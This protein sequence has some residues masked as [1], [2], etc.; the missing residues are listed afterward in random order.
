MANR[1]RRTPGLPHPTAD[2][3]A[4]L[5]ALNR[6]LFQELIEHAVRGNIGFPKDGT[7]PF[8][9]ALPLMIA[10]GAFP[11]EAESEGRLLYDEATGRVFWCDGVDWIP[12]GS[13][14]GGGGISDGDKGDISVSGAGS[15][16]TIDPITVT[17]AKIQN[18]A[19]D[20]LIGRDTAASGSVEE[21]SVGGGLEFT[22]AAAIRRS[23]LTGDVTAGVGS[24]STTIA[25]DAVTF[26]KMQDLTDARLVGRASGAPGDPEHISVAAPLTLAATVLGFDAAADLSNNARVAVRKNSAGS[27]FIR[28]RINLIE[29][30]NVTL[31]VA[32]DAGNEEVDVTVAASGGGG[33]SVNSGTTSVDF[34]AGASNANDTH[35]VVTV[36]GQAGIVAGSLV[37]AWVRGTTSADHNID[38]HMVDELKVEAGNIVAGT[39]FDIHV[40]CVRGKTYGVYNLNWMWV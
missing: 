9:A 20:R 31:T 30:A 14:G 2:T 29:G 38:E 26:A 18:I 8:E 33:G 1:L 23:A 40:T 3:K 16:W 21:I 28:R 11:N 5:D 7:E 36:I 32:D 4:S 24:N 35:K 25:N 34:G 22:G 12:I 19:T 6:A 13:A 27:V 37:Q 39:G 10:T 17:F 15:V